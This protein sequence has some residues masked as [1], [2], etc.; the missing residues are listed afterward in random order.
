MNKGW[1]PKVKELWGQ[2]YNHTQIV[3][4]LGCAKSTVNQHV[5]LN[6]K[7]KTSNRNKKRKQ[8]NPLKTKV[9]RFLSTPQHI[10]AAKASKDTRTVRAILNK[11]REQF[12]R[13]RKSAQPYNK[14][15][16]NQV[17]SISVSS[18]PLASCKSSG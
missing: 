7:Q 5:N 1:G 4:K 14:Y 12:S 18:L 16:F 6:S 13:T 10:P 9:E 15:T 17:L 3:S 8:D 11:K 2:G